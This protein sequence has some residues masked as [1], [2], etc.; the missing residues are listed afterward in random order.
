MRKVITRKPRR[1]GRFRHILIVLALSAGLAG[2][3]VGLSVLSAAPASAAVATGG[4]PY[5]NMAC[6]VYPY[7]RT[8]TAANWCP[9]YNWGTI[10]NNTTNASEL[11]P[12]GYDYRNC[13]D[14]VAWKLSTLG[15]KPA[16]Y[17]GL[18]NGNTW[19]KYA[20]SHGL[21]DND[22]PTVGSVAVSA[23]GTFG[24]VAFVT[25]VKGKIIRVAQ[26][27]QGE[28]GNYSTQS[29]TAAGLGFSSFVHF[30][31][32]ESL[33]SVLSTHRPAVEH[34]QVGR[35]TRQRHAARFWRIPV[36]PLQPPRRPRH[37]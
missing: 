33:P 35:P 17:K 3:P 36:P 30:E 23:L 22:I 26:Y 1:A 4:Y 20:A 7:G 10:R 11:S 37:P 9:G 29:G 12:Y 31:K 2:L 27:N 18:G 6:V 5:W 13:T 24:H 25:G 15:V 21:V 16:R 14:Y 32:Y 8:G 19:G 28:N 34:A